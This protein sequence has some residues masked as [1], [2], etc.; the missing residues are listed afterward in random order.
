LE[1]VLFQSGNPKTAIPSE[2]I[3][4]ITTRL[5]PDQD[6]KEVHQQ[7]TQYME[8]HAPPTIAWEI[9]ELGGCPAS[10]TDRNSVGVRGLSQALESVWGKKPVF[11][12]GGG[13][14]PVVAMLQEKLGA[15][16]VLTGFSLPEDGMHGPNEKLHIPTWERGI[17]ALV[18]FF[19]NLKP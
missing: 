7:L 17:Q 6:P 19:H 8:E 14:I 4:L 10:I 12:R 2:A 5:V 16:S 18:H 9:T 15:D 11:V 3:A 13:T 1:V